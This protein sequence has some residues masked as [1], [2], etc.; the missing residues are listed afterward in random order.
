MSRE[1]TVEAPSFTMH[2]EGVFYEGTVIDIEEADGQFGP[3]YKLILAFDGDV[4]DDGVPRNTWHFVPQQ[5]TPNEKNKLRIF[6]DGLH[7]LKEPVGIG[8]V[9]DVDDLLTKRFKAIFKHGKK[10]DGSPK[11]DIIIVKPAEQSPF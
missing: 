5:Y 7:G 2:D 3:Q 1:Q 10:K 6:W 11:E 8:Q 4:N 9:I